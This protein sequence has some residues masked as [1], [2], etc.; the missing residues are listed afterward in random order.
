VT[1]K[2]RIAQIITGL[3]LGGGGQVM[4]TIA[5]NFDRRR[6]DLDVYCVIGGGELLPEFEKLGVPVRIVPAHV[7]RG[8]VNYRPREVLA[9]A[10]EL[11]HGE[12]DLVHTHLYQADVIGGIAARL[13]G[14]RRRV[15]SLHNMGGWKKSRHIVA[16]KL[17]AGSPDRVVCCSRWLAESAIR[18]E[19]LDPSRVVTIYHGVDVS[20]FQVEVRREEYLRSLGLDPNRRV[21]GTIGRPIEEKGHEYLI[22]AMPAVLARHPDVQ[23]LIVGEGRL[24]RELQQ[25]AERAGLQQLVALP[26]ARPDVPELLSIMDLFVFPSVSEGLGIAILEAMAARVPVVASNIRPISEI[27]VS[28]ETGLLIEPRSPQALADAMNQLLGDE[29][30]ANRLR[31]QAF[32]HVSTRYT[33]KQMVGTLEEVYLDLCDENPRSVV[34][35]PTCA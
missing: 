35:D 22:E 6:F 9:L 17:L 23:L 30:L 1:R 12:Y 4:W 25:R 14:I 10:R 16:E 13:A 20:R 31:A 33:E 15:K 19:G 8:F 24:R 5:R 26:G 21:I 32:H 11:K 28:G 18:Q 3:V 29:P 27:V 7:T 34:A 2:L